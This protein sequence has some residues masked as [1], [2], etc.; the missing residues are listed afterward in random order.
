MEA[1]KN[2]KIHVLA[3]VIVILSEFIGIRKIYIL[4]LVPILYATIMG[5]LISYPKF[6]F[7]SKKDMDDASFIF[8]ISLMILLAK[9]GLGVGPQLQ[10]IAAAKGTIIIQTGAHLLGTVILG[11]PV[12]ILVGLKRE[13]IGATYSLGREAQV[14]IIA[15][16]YGLSSPEGHGVMGIFIV[17]TVLG[18][19]WTSIFTSIIVS[20]NIFH[21]YAL[22]LGAG[23]SS[24]SMSTAAFEVISTGN[25]TKEVLN[26]VQG[27]MNTSNLLVNIVALYA[28][29]FVTLPL[30]V[31]LYEKIN[32][33]K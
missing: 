20:F 23:T 19:L 4:I 14:A 2:W 7:L 10:S 8:P 9:V 24:L 1:I 27:Y 25:F 33:E 6:G 5:G 26:T 13:S 11:L 30:T 32:G 12:A 29:M 17:G 22:G 28:N 3:L 15:D 21:P 31:W 16:K 18:A